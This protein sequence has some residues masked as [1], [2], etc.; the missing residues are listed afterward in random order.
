M[1]G[2]WGDGKHISRQMQCD[3]SCLFLQEI[4]MGFMFQIEFVHFIAQKLFVSNQYAEI[5]KYINTANVL[6]KNIPNSLADILLQTCWLATISFKYLN[7][8]YSLSANS[9]ACNSI[10]WLPTETVIPPITHQ[11]FEPFELNYT[12]T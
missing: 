8:L 4:A 12:F 5:S 6:S 1:L 10:R 9:Y 2:G 3:N 7:F 11:P